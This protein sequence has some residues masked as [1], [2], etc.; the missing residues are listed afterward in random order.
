MNIH[1]QRFIVFCTHSCPLA[2]YVFYLDPEATAYLQMRH[3]VVP[4][5]KSAAPWL[6]SQ[7]PTCDSKLHLLQSGGQWALCRHLKVTGSWKSVPH[8]SS[9]P[10]NS[11]LPPSP[12]CSLSLPDRGQMVTSL[13]E[14]LSVP[15]GACKAPLVISKLEATR[16]RTDWG[17]PGAYSFGSQS[18]SMRPP[19]Q[20][21]FLS[22]FLILSA[23][24]KKLSAGCSGQF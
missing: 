17:P 12:T 9:D 14:S 2:T 22:A 7:A 21:K 20:T 10:R 24:K 19:S 8:S 6:T 5:S 4:Q 11:P 3:L 1:T 23:H 15:F 18:H 13:K 16:P